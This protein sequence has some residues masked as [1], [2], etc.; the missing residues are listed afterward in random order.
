[1]EGMKVEGDYAKSP[2]LAVHRWASLGLVVV[3]MSLLGL[4]TGRSVRA[5]AVL[6]FPLALIWFAEHLAEWAMKNSGGWLGPKHADVAVRATGWLILLVLLGLFGAA[7]W[8][9]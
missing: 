5:G 8:R 1:M 4:G 6:V 3:V 9:R 7:G 2:R